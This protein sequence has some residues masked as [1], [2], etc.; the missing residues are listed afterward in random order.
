MP[1]VVRTAVV[2]V[3][4]AAAAAWGVQKATED[5]YAGAKAYLADL[6]KRPYTQRDLVAEYGWDLNWRPRHGGL[7]YLRTACRA[8]HYNNI[9]HAEAARIQIEI[10]DRGMGIYHLLGLPPDY[11]DRIAR[12][13]FADQG[14]VPPSR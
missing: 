7:S 1:V 14:I 10:E 12:Q 8:H 6:E 13:R 2:I 4:V 5:S 3:I 9:L 11:C